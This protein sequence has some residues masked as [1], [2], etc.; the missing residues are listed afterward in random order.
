MKCIVG[1]VLFVLYFFALSL[2]VIPKCF[3]MKAEI[4]H[5]RHFPLSESNVT[6][7]S[8]G[9]VLYDPECEPNGLFKAKQC[10]SSDVCWCV[11]G[12]GVRRSH[13]GDRNLRCEE[14][15]GPNWVR[16]MMKSKET[17]TPLELSQVQRAI[18]SAIQDQD[19]GDPKIQVKAVVQ[20]LF[21]DQMNFE[22]TIESEKLELE[23]IMVYYVEEKEPT[24][25]IKPLTTGLL[26]VTCV[27]ILT[28]CVGLL[29]LFLIRRQKKA[30]YEK[31]QT[32]DLEEI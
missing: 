26:T 15:V 28:A 23:S 25:G 11:D 19:N 8:V 32:R 20:S 21:N 29:I 9:D 6:T 17:S 5:L 3:K 13:Y 30:Q 14:L 12:A 24:N 2:A 10:K 1:L 31:A 18:A 16:I 22:P 27:F 4:D 7:L